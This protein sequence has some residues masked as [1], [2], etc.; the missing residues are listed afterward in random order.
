MKPRS[1]ILIV[2]DDPSNI[3]V[4][5]HVL[6]DDHVLL[7]T[8][9]GEECLELA[10]DFQPDLILLDVVMPGIG[11]L[12]T[13]RRLRRNR[14]LKHAK[15]ILLSAREQVEERL[16]GYVAGADDYV[17][18]PYEQEELLA[19]VEV[20][21]RL[22]SS[23][24]ISQL[25]SD[26]LSLISH[27]INTPLNGI[28]GPMQML[29]AGDIDPEE[30]AMWADLALQS[31]EKLHDFFRRALILSQ[32]TSGEI[33]FE[34]EVGDLRALVDDVVDELARKA[35]DKGITIETEGTV[36][37]RVAID[38][39]HF[40]G[41]ISAILDNAIRFSTA[42]GRIR[43]RVQSDSERV[44][45]RISDEGVGMQPSQLP[46]VFDPFHD[47]DVRHHDEGHGL[48]LAIA[49]LIVAGHHGRIRVDSVAGAGTTFTVELPAAVSE[50]NAELFGVDR[51]A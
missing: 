25:K 51:A 27:E 6:G 32:M 43:I 26:L 18:K 21:L 7:T 9:T 8:T 4:L 12:E 33:A 20:F 30:T 40:R 24:E 31:A 1:R 41:V 45:L 47:P 49:R 16:E 17:T 35:L 39:E 2:D 15:I 42:G 28:M 46:H 48:S 14:H 50:V 29:A 19:K 36:E 22:K 34:L 37:E 44:L 10:A 11:G 3:A 5:Q 38:R 23:E 13:C